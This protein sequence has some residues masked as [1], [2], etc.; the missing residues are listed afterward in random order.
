MVD[1]HP[2]VACVKGHFGECVNGELYLNH[3][4]SR[5][6]QVMRFTQSDV[7]EIL[8]PGCQMAFTLQVDLPR[9]I[10]NPLRREEFDLGRMTTEALLVSPDRRGRLHQ[11]AQPLG[12]DRLQTKQVRRK[13]AYRRLHARLFLLAGIRSFR[14]SNCRVFA[15]AVFVH[16]MQRDIEIGGG[17]DR[18]DVFVPEALKC[19]GQVITSAACQGCEPHRFESGG[20]IQ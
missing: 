4:I 15:W 3:P 9:E 17:S 7:R 2:K 14:S 16:G 6:N 10:E 18:F 11:L 8:H 20:I 5:E 13:S 19:S 12:L 1:L